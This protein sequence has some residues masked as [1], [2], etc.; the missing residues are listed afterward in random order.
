MEQTLRRGDF[1]FRYLD[2]DDF[3]VPDNAFVICTFWYINAL[4]ALGR[5]EE[6]RRLFEY[7]LDCRTALGLLAE[8]I[9]VTT[10]EQWGN[11]VQTYSMVGLINSAIRLSRRWD[12]AF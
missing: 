11:F 7:V 10:H 4:V 12:E 6:A 1:V 9:D 3:G 2:A 8:H 5:R